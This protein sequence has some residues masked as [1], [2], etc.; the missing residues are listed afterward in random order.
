MKNTGFIQRWLIIALTAFAGMTM[1]S[2]CDLFGD[3]EHC[4]S[5]ANDSKLWL[6]DRDVAFSPRDSSVTFCFNRSDNLYNRCYQINNVC[7]FGALGVQI[8]INEKGSLFAPQPLHYRILIVEQ[9]ANSK[10][11]KIRK[12]FAAYRLSTSELKGEAVLELLDL[13]ESGPRNF[14]VGVAAI[15]P[16]GTFPDL[17]QLEAWAKE[18]IAQVEFKANYVRWE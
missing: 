10:V 13:P 3:E 7:P 2:G 1:W 11:Y 4:Q 18:N 6:P 9:F 15:F 17:F 16:Q 5:E 12:V 8:K 14:F